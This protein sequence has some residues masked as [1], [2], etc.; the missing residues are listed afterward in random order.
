MRVILISFVR[1][2]L[3]I[4]TSIVVGGIEGISGII[5]RFPSIVENLSHPLA[6][7]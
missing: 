1:K 4:F 5:R 2:N 3:R 7:L 6:E